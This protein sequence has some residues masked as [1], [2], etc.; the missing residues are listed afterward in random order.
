[1]EGEGKLYA[2]IPLHLSV[3]HARREIGSVA[4]VHPCHVIALSMAKIPIQPMSN[5]ALFVT[6]Q[7]I[8]IYD[9]PQ[10]IDTDAKGNDLAKA[11]GK[12]PALSI[13]GHGAVVVGKTV[14]ETALLSIHM[15]QAARLQ[16]MA[17]I[18]G[19]PS[20]FP[21]KQIQNWRD[22]LKAYTGG[23]PTE[24]EWNYY[25]AKVLGGVSFKKLR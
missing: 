3:Y 7:D 13:K 11:L 8:P 1:L 22:T 19:K 20:R 15:E 14:E 4:H 24:R 17:N 10:L 16:I 5:E 23:G 2:E 9:D 21:L 6:D 12:R 25:K 18:A